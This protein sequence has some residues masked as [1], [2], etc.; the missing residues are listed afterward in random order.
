MARPLPEAR[1]GAPTPARRER[2]Q[3][4]AL[5]ER[6]QAVEVLAAAVGLEALA[7]ALRVRPGQADGVAGAVVLVQQQAAAVVGGDRLQRVGVHLLAPGA[8]LLADD[9]DGFGALV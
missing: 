5:L 7:V 8:E 4:A 9:E 6:Q 3:P 1:A 2:L